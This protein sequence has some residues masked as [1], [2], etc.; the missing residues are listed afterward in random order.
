MRKAKDY[1]FPGFMLF[2][3]TTLLV[4]G[5]PRFLAEL[6]LVPGTPI[7]ERISSGENVSDEDLDVLEQSRVQ[8][9]GFVEHPR[10]YT[11]LGLVYLLKASRTADP[12][13]KLRYADLA[14][15]NL[16]TG[17][18]LAPLNTFAW[19]RLSSVYILKGEEFHSEALDAWRK[20]VATARFEPF[21]FTSR[22]HVGIMLYA[23]MSTEDV[24]LLRV[25]TE[26]AYNWNRGK[27][28]AYGRQNGLMPW[29]KFLGPQAEAA[30]RYLNS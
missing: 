8:A 11:D 26:L 20:S 23:V 29:L 22:L 13:E 27:V 5:V 6:M 3:S 12:S 4:I 21:V 1:I 25:Q 16:K 30:Q 18:G 19:L 15:E 14:I 2:A 10:S 17:L 28:R 7:Y 24:T 9:I